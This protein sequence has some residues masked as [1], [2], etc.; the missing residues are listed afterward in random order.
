MGEVWAA[1]TVPSQSMGW[2]SLGPCR[3][4][5]CSLSF[6]KWRVWLYG[7]AE[8][9]QEGSRP[10]NRGLFTSVHAASASGKC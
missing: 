6:G 4:F 8:P 1:S 5:G 10:E 7:Q 2:H 3:L 9:C